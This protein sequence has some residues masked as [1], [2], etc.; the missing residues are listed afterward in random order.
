TGFLGS[1]L[2]R[3]MVADGQEVRILVRPTSKLAVL[4]GLPVQQ[5]IGDITDP[6]SV[7]LAVRERDWVVHAAATLSYSSRDQPLHA[8]GNVKGTHYLAEACRLEGVRRLVH[9]SSVAAIG[10]PADP[11]HP[12][13]E[14]FPFNL[15]TSGLSYHLSKQR[16]EAMV[17][18]EV[19]RG[20]NAVVV[21]PASI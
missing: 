12:A 4:D 10:I 2:C 1:H 3:R 16:A 7:R 11:Q 6:A 15:E 13:A 9:V 5:V 8:N 14:D 17:M 20:L 19:A 21:N 18:G